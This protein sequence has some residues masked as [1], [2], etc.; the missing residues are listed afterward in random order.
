MAIYLIVDEARLA[1]AVIDLVHV[2][3]DNVVGWATPEM[4]REYMQSGGRVDRIDEIPADGLEDRIRSGA[5]LLD[6]RGA[7]ELG[8]GR[9]GEAHNIAHTRLLNR[10]GELSKADDL[11]VYCE[12]GIRSAY[13]CGLLDRLGYRATNLDGG[14]VGWRSLG[15]ELDTA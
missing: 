9:I 4:F 11:I 7:A 6:V 5:R 12:T 13:A 15:G 3:L 14:I 10:V 2:G 1:E 8:A